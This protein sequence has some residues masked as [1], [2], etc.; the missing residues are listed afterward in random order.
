MIIEE[1]ILHL[2]KNSDTEKTY[3]NGTSGKVTFEEITTSRSSFQ[4]G[5]LSILFDNHDKI[6]ELL[7]TVA[8]CPYRKH[9]LITAKLLNFIP[10]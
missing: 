1:F 5:L 9:R 8:N 4:S 2:T 10:R 7:K 3:N 6:S